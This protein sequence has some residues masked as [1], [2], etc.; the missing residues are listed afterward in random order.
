MGKTNIKKEIEEMIIKYTKC[1]QDSFII[2][3]LEELR[4]IKENIEKARV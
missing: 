4:E 1:E 2:E 3:Y